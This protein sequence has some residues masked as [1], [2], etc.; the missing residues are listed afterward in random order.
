MSFY[1]DKDEPMAS[2]LTRTL[3]ETG[4]EVPDFLQRYVPEGDALTNLKFEADSDFDETEAQGGGD[5]GWG[6]D[7]EK[8]GDG[9]WGGGGDNAWGGVDEATAGTEAQS[10]AANTD[11]W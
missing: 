9:G 5:G 2:V 11:G 7:N 10:T 6:Q 3:L 4:Q 8:G 1:S